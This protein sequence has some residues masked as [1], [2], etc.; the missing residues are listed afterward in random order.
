L[1]AKYEATQNEINRLLGER[2]S[3]N[4]ILQDS[5]LGSVA[6]SLGQ[7]ET[8]LAFWSARVRDTYGKDE[9]DL[10]QRDQWQETVD[11]LQL[12]QS[13]AKQV[14]DVVDADI[15]KLRADQDRLREQMQDP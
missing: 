1:L 12:R 11:H 6:S 5:R 8:Q 10:K 9:Y 15:A 4:E 14:L 7:A 3:I 13:K 2:Q